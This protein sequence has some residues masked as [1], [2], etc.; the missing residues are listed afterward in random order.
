MVYERNKLTVVQVATTSS[1]RMSTLA[2]NIASIG[3]GLR[4][5]RCHPVDRRMTL[6]ARAT[7]DIR[8]CRRQFVACAI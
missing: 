2:R 1:R 3:D 8:L 5:Q 6:P 7:T 4:L